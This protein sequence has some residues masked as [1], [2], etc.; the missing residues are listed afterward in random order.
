[1][2][3][4]TPL[5]RKAAAVHL[6][7]ES[8]V[9]TKTSLLYL[10]ATIANVL[11]EMEGK[12]VRFHPRDQSSLNMTTSK[13]DASLAGSLLRSKKTSSK[14]RKVAASDLAQ[15]KRKKKR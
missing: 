10:S 7:S 6:N 9:L 14:T 15:A 8:V 13:K 3:S 1:M 4:I 2:V 11:L 5:S 12:P